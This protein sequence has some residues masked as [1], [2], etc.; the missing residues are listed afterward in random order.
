MGTYHLSNSSTPLT[1][2]RPQEAVVLT[3]SLGTQR[4]RFNPFPL[5]S[6]FRPQLPKIMRLI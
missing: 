4:S 2:P 5:L 3:L 1:E 6:E